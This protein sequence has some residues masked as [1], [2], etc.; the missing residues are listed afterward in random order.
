MIH[1]LAKSLRQYKRTSIFTV[2]FSA[3]EVIFEIL[4]PLCMSDL[5]D[6]GIY[7]GN[8]AQVWKYGLVLILSALMQLLTGILSARSAARASAGFAA[9]LRQDMYDNV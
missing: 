9:N 2:F 7:D 6:Y 1:T 4:I 3:V 5:I 8:M